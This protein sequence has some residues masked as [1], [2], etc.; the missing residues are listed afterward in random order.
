M[1][2]LKSFKS[3]KDYNLPKVLALSDAGSGSDEEES[4]LLFI[5]E[6]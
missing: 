2:M 4:G 6:P 5:Q 3:Y 1:V